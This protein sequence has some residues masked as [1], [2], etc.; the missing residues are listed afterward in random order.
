MA[1]RGH[2]TIEERLNDA[3][4]CLLCLAE[5][6]L[7]RC[8]H[9]PSRPAEVRVL[10]MEAFGSVQDLIHASISA[11]GG[12]STLAQIY[13]L[14]HSRGRIAYKRSGGSRLITHNEHWKS[15]IRHAL[16][17][18]PRFQ[19]CA[20]DQ[21][22]WELTPGRVCAPPSI[23]RV[24]VREDAPDVPDRKEGVGTS[25]SARLSDQAAA[26]A[27]ATATVFDERSLTSRAAGG[28]QLSTPLPV[29]DCR[30]R[31]AR[32]L[33]GDRGLLAAG[34]R[35]LLPAGAAGRCALGRGP[36]RQPG[37]RVR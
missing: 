18:N 22:A 21:D 37:R 6:S 9:G 26:P 2:A 1:P 5:G 13:Q 12:R 8:P 11:R 33:D 3:A 32:G 10:E 23:V 36:A 28:A 27:T 19:R 30:A 25:G 17:T 29:G 7:E 14:C 16:Y 34:D 24:L 31:A 35:G 20:D 4:S 15:Q